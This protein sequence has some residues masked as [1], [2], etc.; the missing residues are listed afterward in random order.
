MSKVYIIEAEKKKVGEV[1]V[2]DA[3]IQSLMRKWLPGGLTVAWV[4][5]ATGDV[6]YVDD[7]GLLQPA[8]VAF[9]IRSRPD[10]QPMM[11]HG[12]M[13]G[14]DSPMG[15]VTESVRMTVKQVTA[16]LEWLTVEEAM[17]WFYARRDRPS[18]TVQSGDEA[19]VVIATWQGIIDNLTGGKGYDPKTDEQ[20]RS[21]FIEKR[22]GP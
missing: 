12:I 22:P 10:D 7:E 17:A 16:Q 20:L 1:E 4:F 11:S 19:P 3:G 6:I 9:R 8:T 15:D 5:Q 13:T 21:Q 18:V 14:P 2:D